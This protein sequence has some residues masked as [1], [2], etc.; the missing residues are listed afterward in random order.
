MSI[1]RAD[2]PSDFKLTTPISIQLPIPSFDYESLTVGPCGVKDGNCI[3]IADVG[4]GDVAQ[5]PPGRENQH[6]IH[7]IKEPKWEDF[8]DGAVLPESYVTTLWFDY[9][10]A[11]SPTLKANCEAVFLDTVGWGAGGA[12]GDFYFITKW[13]GSDRRTLNRLFQIPANVWTL[14]KNDP[15]FVVSPEAVGFYGNGEASNPLMGHT[16]TRAEMTLDGTLIA[17]GNYRNQYLFLRCPGKSVAE[18][19]AMEGS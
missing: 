10:H 17:L 9:S 13:E 4:D 8:E 5:R 12:I 14:A 16:W 18:T 1:E 3:Y 6:S 15:N 2:F 11:S 7:K 19:I